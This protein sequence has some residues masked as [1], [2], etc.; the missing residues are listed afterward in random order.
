MVEEQIEPKKWYMNPL[1]MLR[2]R[3]TIFRINIIL[4]FIFVIGGCVTIIV[5]EY[6]FLTKV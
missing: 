3:Q 2:I 4:Y 6:F 1:S 5:R